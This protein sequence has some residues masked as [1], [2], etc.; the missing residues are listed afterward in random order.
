MELA[1]DEK[2]IQ[3]LFSELSLQDAQVTP[4]FAKLWR[5]AS[6]TQR[7]PARFS[8]SLVALVATLIV[9]LAVL[10]VAFSRDKAPTEQNVQNVAPQPIAGRPSFQ[11]YENSERDNKIARRRTPSHSHRRRT[12]ARRPSR[13]PALE[14]Q[15]AML[16][17][18]KSP[19]ANFMTSPTR[20]AF[21]SLPQLN[22]SAKD[23]ESFLS[24]NESL[25]ESNQ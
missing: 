8:K 19:T 11:P 6:V 12:L 7:V 5:A 23:L 25:K 1:G 20:S 14:Q 2:R 22:E 24:T 10:F 3:A 13:E 18:W 21:N 16:A 15:A 4:D 9:A 17:N